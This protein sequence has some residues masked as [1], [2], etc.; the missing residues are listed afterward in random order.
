MPNA[1]NPILYSEC[2]LCGEAGQHEIDIWDGNSDGAG[3]TLCEK[4]FECTG[5]QV[6]DSNNFIPK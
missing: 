6:F 2:R 4:I 3:F 5:A 1:W